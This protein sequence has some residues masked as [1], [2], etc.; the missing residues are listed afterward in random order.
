M[1]RIVVIV[2]SVVQVL[3]SINAK[4]LIDDH[5]LNVDKA[6][7]AGIQCL[8]FGED[9]RWNRR[10]WGMQTPEDAMHYEERKQ[11]GLA[12]PAAELELLAGVERVANWE[13]VV[14]WIEKWDKESALL[15]DKE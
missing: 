1:L 3:K 12:I 11:A 7:E 14:E 5:V 8:L 9:Y 15:A 2:R 6:A 13:A 10:R 4:L